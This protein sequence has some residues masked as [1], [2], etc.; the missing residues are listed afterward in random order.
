[1]V[2]SNDIDDNF[3]ERILWIFV[4]KDYSY[5]DEIDVIMGAGMGSGRSVGEGMA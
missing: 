4:I 1:M 2:D 5:N 3:L